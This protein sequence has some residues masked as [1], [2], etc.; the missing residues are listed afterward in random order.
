MKQLLSLLGFLTLISSFALAQ[1]QWE[2]FTPITECYE[3]EFHDDKA[4]AATDGGLLIIDLQTCTETLLTSNNS[5]IKGYGVRD[6]EILPNGHWWLRTKEVGLIYFDG[7]NYSHI[8]DDFIDWI[9]IW[10]LTAHNDKLWFAASSFLSTEDTTIVEHQNLPYPSFGFAF[11]SQNNLWSASGYLSKIVDNNVVEELDYPNLSGFPFGKYFMHNDRHWISSIEQVAEP[12]FGWKNE[13][14]LY[15]F[16]NGVWIDRLIPN[17]PEKVFLDNASY[18]SFTVDSFYVE[19]KDLDFSYQ[20]INDKFPNLPSNIGTP[21]I[22]AQE[23]EETFWIQGNNTDLTL[24]QLYRVS[25]DSIKGF[26]INSFL[27]SRPEVITI[28]CNGNLIAYDSSRDG[29][30]IKE[31]LWHN[32]DVNYLNSNCGITGLTSD[33]SNCDNWAISN[34]SGCY[35]FWNIKDDNLREYDL[36]IDDNCK[37]VTFD[38]EGNLFFQYSDKIIK[39]D[40][41]GNSALIEVPRIDRFTKILY[42]SQDIL[43]ITGYDSENADNTLI[44]KYQNDIWTTFEHSV[45]RGIPILY[46]DNSGR[47]FFVDNSD[48]IYTFDGSE[49]ILF[50]SDNT[51]DNLGEINDIVVDGNNLFIAT[52]KGLGQWDGIELQ[53]YDYTNSDILD[54]DCQQ[55]KLANDSLLWIR[56]QQGLTKMSI[57]KNS[58]NVH[59]LTLEEPEVNFSL[60]PNPTNNILTANFNSEETR[61]IDIISIAGQVLISKESSDSL[62]DFNLKELGVVEQ[63]CYWMRVQERDGVMLQKFIVL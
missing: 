4:F 47:M 52:Q 19:V 25:K 16:D 33:Q 14:H 17:H 9:N 12:P 13:Y 27:S 32:I 46:E 5:G 59:N 62:I 34:E 1:Q 45:S 10:D 35:S 2:V 30:H 51:L 43:W 39:G 21:E 28:D 29:I 24:P 57:T 61:R 54:K 38:S 23:D 41:L 8:N 50:I 6:I 40:T 7:S 31:D 49:W 18:F 15:Y 55:L 48:Q 42:S 22:I 56:H 44:M 63:G 20:S 26:G 37:R 60:Y 11:D 36:L 3:I 53:L 58:T